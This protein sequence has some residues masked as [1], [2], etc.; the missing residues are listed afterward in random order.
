MAHPLNTD[1]A[2]TRFRGPLLVGAPA[3]MSISAVNGSSTEPLISFYNA[4]EFGYYVVSSA[5]VA[6]VAPGGGAI[7][8]HTSAQS[9]LTAGAVTVATLTSASHTLAAGALTALTLTTDAVRVSNSTAKYTTT[10]TGP[11][12]V[13]P[14]TTAMGSTGFPDPTNTNGGVALI[15]ALTS[16]STGTGRLCVYSTIAGGWMF[17]SAGA[18]SWNVASTVP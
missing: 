17:T 7:Q 14:C 15:F 9:V 4:P 12:L 11:L 2:S 18:G 13:I 5:S 10:T 3:E 1:K 16:G 6:L 8:T